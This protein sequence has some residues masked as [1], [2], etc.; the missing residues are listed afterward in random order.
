M[1]IPN[2]CKLAKVAEK[3]PSRYPFDKI[4]VSPRY[5]EATNGRYLV[6][7]Y[8]EGAGDGMLPAEG[9]KALQ[10]GGRNAEVSILGQEAKNTKTGVKTDLLPLE[11]WPDTDQL[12]PAGELEAVCTVNARYLK[13]ILEAIGT[14]ENT[15]ISLEFHGE[16]KPLVLAV[17]EGVPAVALLMP[18]AD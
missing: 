16:E 4:R 5:I 14:D 8:G 12:F 3:G 9:F 6:R 2:K 18:I 17:R 13:E 10:T 15:T 1:E 7:L 11:D